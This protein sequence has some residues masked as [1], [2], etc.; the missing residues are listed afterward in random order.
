MTIVLRSVKGSN[1]T[2]AEVDGNF[3]DLDDRV[4]EIED[5]PV[6]PVGIANVVVD[7]AT[8]TVVLT[9]T[10][11]LGPFDIPVLPQ[12]PTVTENSSVTTLTPSLAQAN[13]WIRLT[14]AAG[15]TVIVPDDADVNHVVNTEIYFVQRGAEPVSF[16]EGSTD[17]VLNF[18]AGFSNF[19]DG[20]GCSA[21]AKKVGANEWDIAGL[22]A[23]EEVTA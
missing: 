5:N 1:L 23:A 22:L 20:A 21:V 11:E 6:E 7:G 2:P 4:T 14:N 19:T 10:T 3:T 18:P 13:R 8:F 12:T 15:C 17:V 9:D 16:V